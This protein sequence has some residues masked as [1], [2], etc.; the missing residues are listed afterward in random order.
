[1]SLFSSPR[2]RHFWT[3]TLAVVVA[4][5]LTLGLAPAVAGELRD[6]GLLEALFGM[7]VILV[8][9]TIVTQGLR[10]RPAGVEIGVALGIAAAY[11]L[12]FARMAIAEE[13]THLIEYGVVAIF[14]HEALKERASRGRRVPRPALLAVMAT[15][16]IGTIDES[17][18]AVLPSRRF[19]PRDILFNV[20][21]G[22]MAVLASL[23]LGRARR[24]RG[25][26][27]A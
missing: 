16:L 20:L 24:R 1:M 26:G 13:R 12:V 22:V 5:Y 10:M 8:G 2:E 11:L 7:G 9:A 17:I 14:V 19:D 4:I 23:A 15:A 27:N 18:Q 3:W 25:A 6:R 21:A